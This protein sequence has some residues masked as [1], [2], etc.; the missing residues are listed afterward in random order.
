[1]EG[2]VS[3]SRDDEATLVHA[4]KKA[5]EENKWGDNNPKPAAWTFCVAQ[6]SGS[7]GGSGRPKD[8]KAIKSRWQRVCAH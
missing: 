6:L 5:R 4:L 8:V 1:M 7:E 2:N 3:W